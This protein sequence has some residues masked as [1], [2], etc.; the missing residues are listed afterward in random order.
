MAEFA[1]LR[2]SVVVLDK[3]IDTILIVF[4]LIYHLLYEL[5]H[6]LVFVR[7]FFKQFFPFLRDLRSFLS[8]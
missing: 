2:F 4:K 6:R 8:S 7:I 3:S 1:I 5:A